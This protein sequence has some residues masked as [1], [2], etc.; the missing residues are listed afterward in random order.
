MPGR[1]VAN[2]RQLSPV[3]IVV[4]TFREVKNIPILVEAVF[5]VL[6]DAG[7]PGEMIIVDDSSNDGSFEAVQSLSERFP[8][9][10]IVREN[11]RGLSSAVVRG[12]EE[13]RYDLLLCMD[14]DLS[15]P[16]AAIP[17]IILRIE[18]GSADFCI[19]SRYVQGGRTR[20]DWGFLRKINSLGA[21]SLARPLTTARDPMAGF[22]CLSRETF[23][24]ARK[25]GINAIGYKIGLELMIKA[26]CQN[27]AEVPIEF[28]D[29]LHGE[30][31]LTF[32]QQLLYLKHLWSLYVFRWGVVPYLLVCLLVGGLLATLYFL[33]R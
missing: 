9:R 28:A 24:R 32:R 6:N 12:F 22:F 16:P 5:A 11:E 26:G 13:A 23:E 17:E 4:P 27:V 25:A 8:V 14:A 10:I 20:E 21:T 2:D 7:R 19:G 15:H 33:A 3:S 29:R 18:S 30:S 31:K 1:M